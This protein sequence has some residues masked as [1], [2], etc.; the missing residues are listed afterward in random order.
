M[1]I[2]E[3]SKNCHIDFTCLDNYTPLQKKHNTWFR[4]T[5]APEMGKTALW[6]PD[7]VSSGIPIE[8]EP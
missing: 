3:G 6:G 7:I 2:G 1:G 5:L 4:G 8:C